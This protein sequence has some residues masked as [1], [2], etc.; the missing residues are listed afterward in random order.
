[1]SISPYF[2]G[3]PSSERTTASWD[4]FTQDATY[5]FVKYSLITGSLAL[6][7]FTALINPIYAVLSAVSLSQTKTIE[8]IDSLFLSHLDEQ[9]KKARLA[10]E[11]AQKVFEEYASLTQESS[12][13]IR[14]RV[15]RYGITI[16]NLP[17][18]E[19]ARAV[20]GED[21]FHK[22]KGVVAHIEAW[23]K[24]SLSAQR[25]IDTLL[26]SANRSIQKGNQPQLSEQE[27]VACLMDGA[28]ARKKAY[29]IEKTKLLPSR[30]RAAYFIHI[31]QNI[32][33]TRSFD[34]IGKFFAMNFQLRAL[35]TGGIPVACESKEA[36]V[37]SKDIFFITTSGRTLTRNEVAKLPLVHLSSLLFS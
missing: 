25:D 1:M 30:L 29:E 13:D 34:A 10:H 4:T 8:K 31:L 32:H 7:F 36:H 21:I 2:T 27:R 22:L 19:N 33:E 28:D 18:Y 24:E 9:R 5:S 26:G 6:V 14:R 11:V 20:Y 17:Y 23:K 3:I 37:K 12:A 35:T 15:G 16:E